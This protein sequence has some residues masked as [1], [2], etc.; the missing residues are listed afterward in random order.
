[1]SESREIELLRKLLLLNYRE[2]RKLNCRVSKLEKRVREMEG[3]MT[4]VEHDVFELGWIE[5]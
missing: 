2:I 3:D 1:M 5:N 4:S